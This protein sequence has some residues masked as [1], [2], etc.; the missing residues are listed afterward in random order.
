MGFGS[1]KQPSVLS[2]IQ[3]ARFANVVNLC[4]VGNLVYTAGTAGFLNIIDVSVPSK[5][6]V[7]GSLKDTVNF[8]N[9]EG[10]RVAGSN[11]FIACETSARFAVVNISTPSA[12]AVVTSLQDTVHF[13]GATNLRLHPD[14][15]TAWMTTLTRA[16]V[17]SIDITNP[18]APAYIAEQRGP[19]P[20]SSMNGARDV[21]FSN[22][23]KYA[24]VSCDTAN[25]VAVID[26]TDR[27]NPLWVT[28]ITHA[29]I[30]GCR[31]ITL[32]ADG[33]TL[34]VLGGGNA[35]SGFNGALLLF[36]VSTPS[37]PTV[38][39]VFLGYG[40]FGSMTYFAG[41]RSIVVYQNYAYLTSESGKALIVL[42]VSNPRAIRYLGGV[43]GPTTSWMDGAMGMDITN[44]VASIVC[45]AASAFATCSLG[46]LPSP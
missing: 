3:D 40:G 21:I 30:G 22:D 28:N 6:V 46:G 8:P 15:V 17:C 14:G 32:S 7:V 31:G 5:P 26:I 35:S 36:D 43:K 29:M 9:A 39:S 18:A 20:G 27:T 19:T 13:G 37:T 45:F 10:V 42:D 24:F 1:A 34:Y 4:R 41:G 38:I 25:C 33:K 16:S 23:G 11:A 12:P 2:R 44:G